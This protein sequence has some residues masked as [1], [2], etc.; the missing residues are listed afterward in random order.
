MSILRRMRDITVATLN[1]KLESCEDPVRLIDQYLAERKRQIEDAERLYAECARHAESL[2]RQYR[3]AEELRDKRE[4]QAMLAIKAGEEE[5]ARIALQ[6]KMQHEETYAR[7]AE[8]YDEA[9]EPLAELELQLKELRSEVQ[10]VA[11]KRSY[12]Q[13]RMESARLQ[14][15]LNER[16]NRSEYGSTARMFSRLE[17]RVSDMESMSRTLRDVRHITRESMYGAARSSN[18]ALERELELLK[19]KLQEEG[20]GD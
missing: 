11:A 10:E 4:Q 17:D 2:R 16:A 15:I 5:V 12:Y 8:L 19:K 9:L 6:D 14:Q 1:D 3:T 20:G 18:S 7:Y 13:A